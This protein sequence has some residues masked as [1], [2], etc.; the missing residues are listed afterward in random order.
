[1]EIFLKNSKNKNIAQK[2]VYCFQKK[3]HCHV[4]NT[5]SPILFFLQRCLTNIPVVFKMSFGDFKIPKY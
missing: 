5:F 2:Q 4:P 3:N 1:M